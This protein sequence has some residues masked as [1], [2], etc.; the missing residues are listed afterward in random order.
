M[1]ILIVNYTKVFSSSYDMFFRIYTKIT[2]D[3]YHYL[4][5]VCI[6]DCFE[7]NVTLSKGYSLHIG[8]LY[9]LQKS[10]NTKIYINKLMLI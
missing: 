3:E 1:K 4:Y 9:D 5:G 8:V 10:K 2:D 6:N 7:C